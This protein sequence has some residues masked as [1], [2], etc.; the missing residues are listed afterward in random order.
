M[1]STIN[2]K[3][4]LRKFNVFLFVSTFARSLIEIFISLYLFK[5][6][7]SIQ[8]VLTFYLL[9]NLFSFFISILFV[10]IGEKYNYAVVMYAGVISFIV[11]QVVLG[12]LV[13]SFW[14]ISLISLLYA[15]YRRGYWVSRRFYITNIMPEKGSTVPYSIVMVVSEIASILSGFVGAYLLDGLNV[16][17]LMVI[18]SI[19]LFISVLPLRKIKANGNRTKIEL[20]KNLKKYDKRNFIAFSLYEINNLISFIFPIYVYL[21]I[22]GT[23]KMAGSMNAVSNVA[24]IIFIFLYGRIIKKK[25]FFIM[26]TLLFIVVCFSKLIFLNYFILAICFIE[27]IVKKMQNQSLG[28]IYFENRNGMDLAHYNLIYQLLEAVARVVATIPLLFMNDVRI[29]IITVLG[30]ITVE[31]IIYTIINKSK[32]TRKSAILS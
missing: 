3:N 30:I 29:M 2:S 22:E 9:E 4:D 20:I 25:N 32:K 23:Y 15:V 5:N 12:N 18:S 8:S 31:L 13:H 17:T 7:F 27:G 11:L 6:G 16:T 19:L 28:K 21:Y 14:Y 24:I 1:K 26:S 10:K